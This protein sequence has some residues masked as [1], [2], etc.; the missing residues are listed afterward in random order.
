MTEG[1]VQ[2]SFGNYILWIIVFGVLAFGTYLLINRL[3]GS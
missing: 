1:E 3:T 2:D